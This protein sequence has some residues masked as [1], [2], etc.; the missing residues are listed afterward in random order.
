MDALLK[1]CSPT[2]VDPRFSKQ[3]GTAMRDLE[4]ARS[5]IKQVSDPEDWCRQA[6]RI[7]KELGELDDTLLALSNR[8]ECVAAE[9]WVVQLLAGSLS[10]VCRLK[11][12]VAAQYPT[13]L[14]VYGAAEQ[15][16][17]NS[18]IQQQPG[19]RVTGGALPA[20]WRCERCAEPFDTSEALEEHLVDCTL[21]ERI[22]QDDP[23]SPPEP[24]NTCGHPGTWGAPTRC[25]HCRRRFADFDEATAHEYTCSAIREI[26]TWGPASPASPSKMP[27][28][29]SPPCSPCRTTGP[30]TLNMLRAADAASSASRNKYIL[31]VYPQPAVPLDL[32]ILLK[33]EID[34]TCDHGRPLCVKNEKIELY[35]AAVG[36]Q[37][38][39]G[40]QLVLHEKLLTASPE[41][42]CASMSQAV[43]AL[44]VEAWL[45][46]ASSSAKL[47]LMQ[48]M[49]LHE[50]CSRGIEQTFHALRNPL[51]A[52]GERT[53]IF[54]KTLG[55]GSTDSGLLL[56]L[57]RR[58]TCKC[59]QSRSVG[60]ALKEPQHELVT[61]EQTLM[62]ATVNKALVDTTA[63]L[64][65][66]VNVD[67]AQQDAAAEIADRATDGIAAAK[68]S[69]LVVHSEAVQRERVQEEER[70]QEEATPTATV[71][72]EVVSSDD[73]PD[74]EP[75]V[76]VV[77]DAHSCWHC[78][79]QG[80]LT[81]CKGCRCARYCGKDCWTKDWRA[82]HKAKCQQLWLARE[83][84]A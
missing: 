31:P 45:R 29:P 72:R 68:L 13:S 41:F 5:R 40:H 75:E 43:H 83:L 64:H 15:I 25:G 61:A 56:M 11:H 65:P 4:A 80:K 47:L 3:L 51:Q 57:K 53:G 82:G 32:R 60:E 73:E 33:P 67:Q 62:D 1:A 58:C 52:G 14:A 16:Y 17:E 9:D 10:E 2:A 63:E 66:V 35:L 76:V 84:N 37:V 36:D 19:M 7:S 71:R 81:K 79:K 39:A 20:R 38:H 12:S 42:S 77:P 23:P 30:P 24:S 22:M 18:S 69:S 46:G 27:P 70:L 55:M 49:I 48:S 59:L 78:G 50:T 8:P 74:V 6:P 26:G 44:A 28:S 54:M 34:H 21:P